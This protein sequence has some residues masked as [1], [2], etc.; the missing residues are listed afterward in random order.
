MTDRQY[1]ELPAGPLSGGPVL[2]MDID[3]VASPVGQ[4]QRFDVDAPIPGFVPVPRVSYPVHVHPA[5]PAWMDA[6]EQ[7][8]AHCV[9]VS[10]WRER[11]R[12]FA[13]HAG[14]QGAARWPYLMPVDDPPVPGERFPASKIEAVRAWVTPETP[15]AIVDDHL[16][17]QD[18][19]ESNQLAQMKDSTARFV[20]RP[21]P[22]L[23]IA[24]DK[25]IGLTRPIVELLCRFARDPHDPAFGLRVP[26][27]TDS[28]WWVQ[29]PWPLPP[30]QEQPVLVRPDDVDAWHNERA[31][32]LEEA[33]EKERERYMRES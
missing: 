27:H 12:R 22:V 29:W 15:V 5:L 23:L 31:A 25:H 4:N 18:Y 17:Y 20:Q 9:W 11:C 33:R 8:F 32:L 6:L 28:Y 26:V 13:D 3:G 24:P 14:L 30:G 21:G 7:A 16:V 10:S 1:S 2:C 19:D